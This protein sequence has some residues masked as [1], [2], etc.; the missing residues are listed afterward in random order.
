MFDFNN[1]EFSQK[2]IDATA[3]AYARGSRTGAIFGAR[4]VTINLNGGKYV[5][6]NGYCTLGTFI[7][8]AIINVNGAEVVSKSST[9]NEIGPAF[10]NETGYGSVSTFNIDNAIVYQQTG[11]VIEW[12]HQGGDIAQPAA[13]WTINGGDFSNRFS[14]SGNSGNKSLTINGGI[15]NI[16]VS[17]YLGTGKACVQ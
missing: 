11:N 17:A 14:Y 2:S 8:G 7:S 12:S 5:S 6:D 15:Y 4:Q 16:D 3:S 9:N 1:C 10:R 13:I